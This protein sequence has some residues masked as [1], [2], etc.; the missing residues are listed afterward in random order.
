M[1]LLFIA[2]IVL[3]GVATALVLR[4][5]TAPDVRI[6]SQVRQIETYGFKQ[7]L[8]LA[9]LGGSALSAGLAERLGGWAA[10][11]ITWLKPLERRELMAAGMYDVGVATFH[12]YRLLATVG[13]PA[14]V[15]AF[16]LA[17]SGSLSLLSV[18]LV[19][20]IGLM[21]WLLPL[22]IVRS[23]GRRRLNQIDRDLPELI[24]VLTATIEA[25]LGFGGSLQL[26]A[27]RFGGPL[28]VE[29]RLTLQEQT[30]G[31]STDAALTNMLERCETPSV[32]GFVKTMLQG[33]SLGVSVGAMLRNAAGESR[34]RRRALAREHAQKAPVKLLFP[35][36]FLIFPALLIV[37][38]YP[39]VH[40]IA[41][42]L[43]GG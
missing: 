17:G 24:D 36:V 23:R 32:R 5:A 12:G 26:V 18:A 4:A 34:R 14:I 13:L 31:L 1:A 25:G 2:G 39:M 21:T 9:E 11:R 33:D 40:N 3:V 22:T 38:M 8:G 15:V 19:V 42:A 30:M 28:G 10:T 37:L 6:A 7:E 41:H 20:A 43:G 29:L 27:D 35:L 16:T